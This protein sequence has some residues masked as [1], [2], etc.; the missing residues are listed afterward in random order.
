MEDDWK[1]EGGMINKPTYNQDIVARASHKKPLVYMV[2]SIVLR[3][4]SKILSA[5]RRIITHIQKLG[6]KL[7]D[8]YVLNSPKSKDI[9]GYYEIIYTLP[10]I[11]AI[12]HYLHF[13]IIYYIFGLYD[14]FIFF[15]KKFNSKHKNNDTMVKIYIEIATMVLWI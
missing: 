8:L 2:L 15:R 6:G 3:F 13:I 10:P 1:I 5:K 14:Q 9:L 4:K 11:F 12:I 7:T